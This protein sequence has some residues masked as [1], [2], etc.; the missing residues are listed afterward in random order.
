MNTEERDL[1]LQKIYQNSVR[2]HDVYFQVEKLNGKLNKLEE[3]QEKLVFDL[4][5]VLGIVKDI[6]EKL[7]V[8]YVLEKKGKERS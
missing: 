8:D 5:R 3:T 4:S 6:A 7:E 1:K 2:F